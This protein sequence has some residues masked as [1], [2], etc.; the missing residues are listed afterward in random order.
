[1]T[2]IPIN[3]DGVSASNKGRPIIHA[4]RP[5]TTN[6]QTDHSEELVTK[7]PATASLEC[8]PSL[9]TSGR[10]H[11]R[12]AHEYSYALVPDDRRKAGLKLPSIRTMS[13]KLPVV[14]NTMS[15]E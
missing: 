13:T 6:L 9:P 11:A 2:Q 10:G 5:T 12:P 15:R 3:G 7:I 8:T 1:V 4:S 14:D